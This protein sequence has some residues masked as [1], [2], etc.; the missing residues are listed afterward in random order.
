MRL[1]ESA[2]VQYGSVPAVRR[3]CAPACRVRAGR[4]RGTQDDLDD[5]AVE[6]L[7]FG[8]FEGKDREGENKDQVFVSQS[9]FSSFYLFKPIIF[10]SRYYLSNHI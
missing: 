5:G 4:A 6:E 3:A 10:I 2:E 9:S 8:W 1:R 7:L